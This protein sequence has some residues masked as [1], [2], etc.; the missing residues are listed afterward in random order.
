ML[1]IV[2]ASLIVLSIWWLYFAILH[3][4]RLR[5]ARQ[6]IKWGY[7]HCLVFGAGDSIGAGLAVSADYAMDHSSITSFLASQAV[8]I[9]VAGYLVELWFVQIRGEKGSYSVTIA[10]ATTTLLML[11]TP[12]AFQSPTLQEYCSSLSQ[13]A[14]Y[15][16]VETMPNSRVIRTDLRNH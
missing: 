15:C 7:A 8:E 9:P 6:E 10:Y 4:F 2:S 12:F 1:T 16:T 14:L 11:A 13:G 3:H 5:S